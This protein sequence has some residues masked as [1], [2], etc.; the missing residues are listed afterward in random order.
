MIETAENLRRDY[1]I[2]RDVLLGALEETGFTTYS[3][4]GAYYIMTDVSELQ[5]AGEDDVAFA[6]RL[7]QGGG[8]ATVP[9]SSFYA[10]AADGSSLVRFCFSKRLETL[11]RAARVLRERLG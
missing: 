6:R 5:R 11:E 7:V 4:M 3:P 1:E 10:R 2:R 9:G 8:V